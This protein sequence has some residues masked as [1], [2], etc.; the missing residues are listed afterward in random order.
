MNQRLLRDRFLDSLLDD[1]FVGSLSGSAVAFMLCG[2]F[3]SAVILAIIWL[4]ALFASA[5]RN[6]SASHKAANSHAGNSD[7]F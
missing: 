5:F 3:A 6:S 1:G 7:R 2:R 4:I